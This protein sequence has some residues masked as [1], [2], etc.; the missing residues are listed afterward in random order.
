MLRRTLAAL[1]PCC[2]VLLGGCGSLSD[3]LRLGLPKPIEVTTDD[4][5]ADVKVAHGQQLI[6][7]LPVLADS[8]YAWALREPMSAV[9]KPEGPPSVD[10]AQGTGAASGVEVWIFT[11]VR[12]GQ[13][14]LRF[15]HRRGVQPDAPA[16]AVVSYNVSVR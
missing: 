14:Q 15:E 12:D 11:P 3:L 1:V 2:A 7:R 8:G 13:Q 4:S 16:A 6:V 9:V 5:G 10:K